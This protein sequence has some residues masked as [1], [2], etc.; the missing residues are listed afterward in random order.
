MQTCP[1]A[2]ESRIH[3][4]DRESTSSILHSPVPSPACLH[5]SAT[6][7]SR[8]TPLLP[9]D[10]QKDTQTDETRVCAVPVLS[11]GPLVCSTR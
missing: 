11:S 7:S 9:T 3:T 1:Q 4:S 10:R 5:R 6:N 8:L 2:P